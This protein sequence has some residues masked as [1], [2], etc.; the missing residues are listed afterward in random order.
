MQIVIRPRRVLFSNLSVYS[1]CS[2]VVTT[3]CTIKH[4]VGVARNSCSRIHVTVVELVF[5]GEPRMYVERLK[6]LARRS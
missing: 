4:I 3:G 5:V 2:L 1:L 6:Q